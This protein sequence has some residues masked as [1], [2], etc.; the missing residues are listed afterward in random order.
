MRN[1]D[2][3]LLENAYQ[4]ILES[5]TIDDEILYGDKYTPQFK[6]TYQRLKNYGFTILDPKLETTPDGIEVIKMSNLNLKN[7]NAQKIVKVVLDTG[8]IYVDGGRRIDVR[9]YLGDD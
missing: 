3:I 8:E 7:P 6:N 1:R 2:T 4:Q 5:N 9:N